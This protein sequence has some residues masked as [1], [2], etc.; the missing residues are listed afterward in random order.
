MLAIR[1]FGSLLLGL[2]GVP[3]RTARAL[4]YRAGTLAN[5]PECVKAW[6]G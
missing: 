3:D 6:W 4:A 5:A 2:A 1:W